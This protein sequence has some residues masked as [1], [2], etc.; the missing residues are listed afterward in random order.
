MTC[1]IHHHLGKGA[2]ITHGS[3]GITELWKTI[4]KLV[5]QALEHPLW[6]AAV[7][8]AVLAKVVGGNE[9]KLAQCRCDA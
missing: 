8:I 5:C 9:T 6:V 3:V 4:G 2:V 1:L 7:V